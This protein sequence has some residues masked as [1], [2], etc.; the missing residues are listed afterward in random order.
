MNPIRPKFLPALTVAA[1][2]PPLIG[3][4]SAASA[5]E[6]CEKWGPFYKE[7]KSAMTRWTRHDP[8]RRRAG[9]RPGPGFHRAD[10]P[11]PPGGHRHGQ[12]R[13]PP[14]DR[15]RAQEHRPGSHRRTIHRDRVPPEDPDPPGGP[16][17]HRLPS[18]GSSGAGK[19]LP[20]RRQRGTR[21]KE[22]TRRPLPPPFIAR[23]GVHGR[24][25]FQH[26]VVIDPSTINS[27]A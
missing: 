26:G 15:S 2:I 27:W 25:G 8:G 3:C 4:L 19:R 16:P 1:G 13:A 23:P 24:P 21:A 7:T 10:D 17:R 20:L 12:G 5:C 9:R 18:D 6:R 11:A 14:R 22:R